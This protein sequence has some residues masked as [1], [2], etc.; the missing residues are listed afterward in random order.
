M[1]RIET[2]FHKRSTS[3]SMDRVIELHKLFENLN[4]MAPISEEYENHS[5]F[6]TLEEAHKSIDKAIEALVSLKKEINKETFSNYGIT[7]D[8]HRK[9][10]FI[11]KGRLGQEVFQISPETLEIIVKD[12]TFIGKS[13]GTLWD[14][15]IDKEATEKKSSSAEKNPII[16][17][18]PT[19]GIPKKIIKN[20]TLTVSRKEI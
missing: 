19:E 5:L 12:C 7:I 6:P 3:P 4:Y 8:Y 20:Q 9:F 11:E 10:S 15:S 18:G 16:N 13:N 2:G 14:F 17:V 1:K